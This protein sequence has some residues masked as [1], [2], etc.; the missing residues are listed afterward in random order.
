MGFLSGLAKGIGGLAKAAGGIVGTA[1]KIAAPFTGGASLAA[2]AGLEAG[3]N[4]VGGVA[5]TVGSFGDTEQTQLPQQQ[6]QQT[7]GFDMT[8]YLP[9]FS[10]GGIPNK[11]KPA[12][13]LDAK[14]RKP[15]ATMNEMAPEMIMP[16]DPMRRPGVGMMT[17]VQGYSGML[18]GYAGLPIKSSIVTPNATNIQ[19]P[20][21]NTVTS[22][23]GNVG[24]NVTENNALVGKDDLQYYKNKAALYDKSIQQ[25]QQE[26]PS[27]TLDLT[28]KNPKDV[29]AQPVANKGI[30]FEKAPTDTRQEKI[31]G[32]LSKDD[33]L[34]GIKTV[35]RMVG[36]VQDA[37]RNNLGL[38]PGGI[39]RFLTMTDA[40][41]K[42]KQNKEALIKKAELDKLSEKEKLKWQEQQNALDRKSAMDRALI[43]K[44]PKDKTPDEY[45]ALAYNQMQ[46]DIQKKI[47]YKG[48]LVKKLTPDEQNEYLQDQIN[49]MK[50]GERPVF[51]KKVTEDRWGWLPDKKETVKSYKNISTSPNAQQLGD[52]IG[53]MNKPDGT[54]KLKDGKTVKVV[55]GKAYVI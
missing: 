51:E 12:I 21:E 25:T 45:R 22:N 14:T 55:G 7:Q 26:L 34:E 24:Q 47:K 40:L 50:T 8:Q 41:D 13:I 52:P 28:G 19:Q 6:I 16:L 42:D 44:T 35:A 43:D 37:K 46:E 18:K 36:S 11:G 53:I 30:I 4:T 38:G 29:G 32:D 39:T 1:G 48:K 49:Y 17:Q 27:Y 20:V 23:V 2:T 33:F 9:K 10:D 3:L 15:V 31:F 54:Y 5:D